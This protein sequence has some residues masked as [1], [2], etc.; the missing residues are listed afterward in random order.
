VVRLPS[1]AELSSSP[2]PTRTGIFLIGLIIFGNSPRS[3]R[4]ETHD[5]L[6]RI[7][8]KSTAKSMTMKWM[9]GQ[10]FN[11]SGDPAPP[12]SLL[13]ALLLFMLYGLLA[14]LS[15]IGFLGLKACTVPYPSFDTLPAS[16]QTEAD[17]RALVGKNFIKGTAIQPMTSSATEVRIDEYARNGT[18]RLMMTQHFSVLST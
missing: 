18:I 3:S 6:N 4:K 11:K 1:F 13:F 2:C 8:G 16:I 9:I 7:V 5:V 10:I 14:S 15:D 12:K 17:A